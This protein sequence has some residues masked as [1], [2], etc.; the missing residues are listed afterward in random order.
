MIVS[1][2]SFTELVG[3]GAK[4]FT[5]SGIVIGVVLFGVSE[6]PVLS[7]TGFVSDGFSVGEG[8]MF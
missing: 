3:A 2:L 4:V 6:E 1:V 8:V 7:F 5:G